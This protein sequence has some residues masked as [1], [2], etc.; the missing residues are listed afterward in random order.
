MYIPIDFQSNPTL[1]NL[2]MFIG[3]H[4]GQLLANNTKLCSFL[5][6]RAKF[7]LRLPDAQVFENGG[8]FLVTNVQSSQ[9]SFSCANGVVLESRPVLLF[10]SEHDFVYSRK[11]ASL[12]S[13][14]QT[15]LEYEISRNLADF[16]VETS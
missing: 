1:V 12:S 5:L 15:P 14:D 7:I 9:V 10:Q 16:K 8:E 6:V 4:R 11:S 2:V 3:D 13:C